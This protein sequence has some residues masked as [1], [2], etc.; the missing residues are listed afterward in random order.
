MVKNLHKNGIKGILFTFHGITRQ[1]EISALSVYLREKV[2]AFFNCRSLMERKLRRLITS[3]NAKFGRDS[4]RFSDKNGWSD[5]T[6]KLSLYMYICTK[7]P[8]AT[9]SCN[10][11]FVNIMA[12]VNERWEGDSPKGQDRC[13]LEVCSSMVCSN[14]VL[15]F[16]VFYYVMRSEARVLS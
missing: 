15:I 7:S 6:I 9:R 13:A 12:V 10:F 11:L 16:V 4:F 3:F 8:K 2:I 5:L 14:M 1:L